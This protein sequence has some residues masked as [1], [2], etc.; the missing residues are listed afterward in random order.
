MQAALAT[1]GDVPVMVINEQTGYWEPVHEIIQLHPYNKNG[2]MNRAEP[3][4]AIALSRN[5]GNS[6][7]RI[8]SS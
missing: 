2:C 3:V 4:N 5:E 6:P 1:F 8:L 7:D